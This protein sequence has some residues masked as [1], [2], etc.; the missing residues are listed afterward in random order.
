MGTNS[1]P[2][3]SAVSQ[4]ELKIYHTLMQGSNVEIDDDA[5]LVLANLLRLNV[6]PDEIYEVIKQ[7]APVCG[8]LKRFRLKPPK[9]EIEHK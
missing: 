4:D 6:P 2:D 9:T 5:L 7:V 3:A 1:H 8:M